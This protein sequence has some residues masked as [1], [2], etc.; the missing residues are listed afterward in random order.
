MEEH[1]LEE[2][3]ARIQPKDKVAMEAARK[4]WLLIAKPLF[5]LG[6]L[7]D[8]V[9]D[10]AGM[11]RQHD[12]TLDKRGLLIF[13]GDNGVV[14]EGVTQ[15]GQEVTAIVSD[16]F[17]KNETS[18]CK[19]AQ[20][21][22][23]DVIPIDIGIAVDVP[24][25]TRADRKVAYGTKNMTKGPAMTREE[26]TKAILIG[27]DVVRT[28]KEEG[29]NILATGEMGIGN[30][31]TS[32]AIASV[33][34]EQPVSLVTGKGAGLTNEGLSRKIH[35]I[36]KAIEVNKPN[37][38]DPL[39][40]IAKVGGLDIAGLVGAFLGGAIYQI[41]IVID[42]FICAVAALV[43]ARIEPKALD[44]M[45]PSHVSK[46]PA[47]HMVLEALGLKPYITC[48]MCLGEGTGAVAVL[49]LLDMGL[50]VYR[51]MSTFEQIKIDNYEVFES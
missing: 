50:A 41:P 3:I 7:E 44:Y 14:E 32:S 19:M 25:I 11:K 33:L 20:I 1:S 46:E 10:M 18:V 42:G 5:S 29:Y 6:K 38:E 2:F 9:I 12:Y 8:A 26:A 28:C 49:P 31:T 48:D 47:G 30:T 35:A 17:S 51:S 39:D 4:H 21:A 43:A 34:L 23:A 40:V 24:S 16:N 27:I 36:E 37:K 13:C 15:T 45:M 22:K